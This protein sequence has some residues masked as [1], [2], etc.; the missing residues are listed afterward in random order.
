MSQITWDTACT[1]TQ[2]ALEPAVRPAAGLNA[3]RAWA[4]D[5][6]KELVNIAEAIVNI[7]RSPVAHLLRSESL[8]KISSLSPIGLGDPNLTGG[9]RAKS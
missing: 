4:E 3:A 1:R 5:A 8:Q 6:V 7:L 2:L 9:G